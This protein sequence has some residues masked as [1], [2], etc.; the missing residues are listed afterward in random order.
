MNTTA[1][2]E[3]A[4]IK[5]IM[6]TLEPFNPRA[7]RRIMGYVQHYLKSATAPRAKPPAESMP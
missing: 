5:Q 3:L 2:E 4:A 6:L 7:R 1:E